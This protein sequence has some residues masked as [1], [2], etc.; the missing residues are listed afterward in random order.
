MV[1]IAARYIIGR[2]KKIC[3]N[4]SIGTPYMIALNNILHNK[5]D[6]IRK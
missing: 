1:L 6:I 3:F 4:G 5:N 2:K